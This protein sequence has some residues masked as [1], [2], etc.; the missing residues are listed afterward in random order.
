MP[1][2]LCSLIL[3]GQ[4]G[5]LLMEKIFLN[6]ENRHYDNGIGIVMTTIFFVL[7]FVYVVE[8]IRN[9]IHKLYD[10]VVIN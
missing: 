3:Y 7:F 2:T 1:R 10:I 9:N 8:I 4:G 5:F 6:I